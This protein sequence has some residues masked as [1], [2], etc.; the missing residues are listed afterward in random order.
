[1]PH[2]YLVIFNQFALYPARVSVFFVY[3]CVYLFVVCP[4]VFWFQSIENTTRTR[5]RARARMLQMILH[6]LCVVCVSVCLFCVS[7]S[8]KTKAISVQFYIL[9]IFLLRFFVAQYY[10]HLII[11]LSLTITFILFFY[12]LSYYFWLF[13]WFFPFLLITLSL[14][15][16]Y[17]K[18]QSGAKTAQKTHAICR[19]FKYVAFCF[20]FLLF[21]LVVGLLLF[22]IPP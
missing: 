16:A 19:I 9:L 1:M 7:S 14:F 18:N 8:D 3:E 15:V 17:Q 5:A 2:T 20:C 4:C 21:N 22:R 12:F 13:R 10:C 6:Q 11:S